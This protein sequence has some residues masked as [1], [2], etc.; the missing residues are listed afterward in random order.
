MTRRPNYLWGAGECEQLSF[1]RL[2]E[3]REEAWPVCLTSEAKQK[4][5]GTEVQTNAMEPEPA[6]PTSQSQLNITELKLVDFV[7]AA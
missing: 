7:L 5:A 3:H 1:I 2:G 6:H 4:L